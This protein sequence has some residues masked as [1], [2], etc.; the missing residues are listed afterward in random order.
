MIPVRQ[1]D[2]IYWFEIGILSDEELATICEQS[3]REMIL[4]KTTTTIRSGNSN[5]VTSSIQKSAHTSAAGTSPAGQLRKTMP[6]ASNYNSSSTPSLFKDRGVTPTRRQVL[7]YGVPS[8]TV[9]T[10]QNVHNTHPSKVNS[11]KIV[12]SK[13]SMESVSSLSSGSGSERHHRRSKSGDMAC[14]SAYSRQ[15]THRI[16]FARGYDRLFF[17]SRSYN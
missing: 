16:P 2:H 6:L 11:S 13:G 12:V 15:V 8:S 7:G 4:R 10:K 1:N 14:L 17:Y 3:H 9:N 5:S